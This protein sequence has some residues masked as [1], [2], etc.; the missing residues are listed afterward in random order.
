MPEWLRERVGRTDDCND[1]WL[2]S[3]FEKIRYREE[4]RAGVFYA[5]RIFAIGANC[6][7]EMMKSRTRL[8]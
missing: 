6:L 5:V 8:G 1:N 4:E 3:H 7:R 2:G